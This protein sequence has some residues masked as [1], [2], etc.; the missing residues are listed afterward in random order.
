MAGAPKISICIPSFNCARF[1]AV[2]IESV[3]SQTCGDFELIIVDDCS[4]DE[5]RAIIAG[6]AGRDRR[7]TAVFNETNRGMVP[8]WNY[9]I[10]RCRGEY[11]RY[12]FA[13]D[14][15]AS[16]D[17]LE[18]MACILDDDK[19]VSLV[20]S[21]RHFIDADGKVL[22]TESRFH[23]RTVATGTA[24][25]NRC[26]REGRNLIGEPSVVMFRKEQ[27]GRGFD[28]RYRQL[29]DLEMWFHLL[30]QG[31]FVFLGEPLTS[32]RVHPGQQT[33]KN[34]RDLAH[35]DDMFLLLDD[36]LDR[37]YIRPGI[38]ARWF[39]RY[40][41]SYRIWKLHRDGLLDRATAEEKIAEHCDVQSFRRLL[42]V[43]KVYSP[44]LKARNVLAARLQGID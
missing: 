42:P 12:L 26:L 7:I 43:Y 20:A 16:A 10:S 5:S 30:E 19:S 3:L 41:Q 8:N 6:Y 24:I 27:A 9:C 35:I 33:R 36:Y 2:A 15:F 23:D 31:R 25:I 13:D 44:Y 29:V 18:R 17:A 4:S 40:N 11:I 32:F 37:E 34:V 22:K 28:P 1:L 38:V 21:A 14:L 39:L